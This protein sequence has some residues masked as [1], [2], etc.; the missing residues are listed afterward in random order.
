MKTNDQEHHS[1]NLGFRLGSLERSHRS[2]PDATNQERIR[3]A[4]RID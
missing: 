3:F 1:S 4:Y 2:L